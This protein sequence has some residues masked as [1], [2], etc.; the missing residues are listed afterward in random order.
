MCVCGVQ[1]WGNGFV[2][3]VSARL[4]SNGKYTCESDMGYVQKARRQDTML[5][6]RGEDEDAKYFLGDEKALLEV[7]GS[8]AQACTGEAGAS[9]A[10]GTGTTVVA[11]VDRA[12][13][14]A[15][16][17]AEKK[18][19]AAGKGREAWKQVKSGALL[20]AQVAHAAKEAKARADA[21]ADAAAHAAKMAARAAAEKAAADEALQ[22]AADE[23]FSTNKAAEAAAPGNGTRSTET[24]VRTMLAAKVGAGQGRAWQ[25]MAG[26]RMAR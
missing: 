3:E 25:G 6:I 21:A 4:K 11:E 13:T 17:A 2:D 1:V 5:G 18:A 8:G 20:G 12:L 19:A 26:N 7:A 16:A 24:S 15:V 23:A 22:A 10:H 9:S 14:A